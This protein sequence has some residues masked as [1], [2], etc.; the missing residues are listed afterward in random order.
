MAMT[1]VIGNLQKKI[2]I[3]PARITR[4]ARKTLL[5]NKVKEARLSIAFVTDQRIK[6]LN[7]KYLD[8]EYTTDVLSF[9]LSLDVKE[10]T[11][12][13]EIVISTDTALR[14][15]KVFG[16]SV[17]KEIDLYVIHGILHL[18]GFDDHTQRDIQEI[19]TEE[20]KILKQLGYDR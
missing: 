3:K 13:G 5:N 14:N 9:D 6:S 16:T 7:K 20:K 8:R 4:T 2:L 12:E 10:K 17:V 19:R 11:L 15:S 1:I 18:L